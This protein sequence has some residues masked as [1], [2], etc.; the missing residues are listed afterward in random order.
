MEY[1]YW[2]TGVFALLSIIAAIAYLD[3]DT[4]ET[5][6]VFIV[7]VIVLILFVLL[8]TYVFYHPC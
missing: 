7:S 5:R 8:T 4:K 6:H 2:L 1:F 3:S